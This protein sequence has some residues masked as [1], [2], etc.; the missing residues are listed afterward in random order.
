MLM[1]AHCLE[2]MSKKGMQTLPHLTDDVARLVEDFSRE[3][4]RGVALLGA[5][6]LDDALNLMLRA[7][8]V[9][10]ADAVNRLIGPGRPLETFGACTHLAYCMGLIGPD[11]YADINLIREIRNDFAH[12]QPTQ[13]DQAELRPKCRR[14]PGAGI[15]PWEMTCQTFAQ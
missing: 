6:F 2:N 13:F 15:C 4:D 12:R 9:D 5:A 14:F 8:L 1:P 10:D 3:T 7:A 11:L